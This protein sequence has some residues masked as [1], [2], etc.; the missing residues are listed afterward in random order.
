MPISS[1]L[2]QI[3]RAPGLLISLLLCFLLQAKA[4]AVSTDSLRLLLQQSAHDS[5]K[6]L[7]L[8]QLAKTSI[9]DSPENTLTYAQQALDLSENIGFRQGKVL[10]LNTL[11]LAYWS[12]GELRKGLSYFLDSKKEAKNLGD[13]NLFAQNLGSLGLIYRASGNYQMSLSYYRSA[14]PVF[15]ELNNMERIAT[16]YNNMGKCFLEMGV[17]DS[18][19]H[20]FNKSLPL[21]VEYRPRMLPITTFNLAD[22]WYRQQQYDKAIPIL[23]ECLSHAT[24]N[25][26]KR[27]TIRSKQLM[28]EIY[29]LEN[30]TAKAATLART[31]V[32]M[33]E[34]SKVKELIYLSYFTLSK[35]LAAQQCYEQAYHYSHLSTLYKDS[36]Q[37][38]DVQQKLDF[39][40]FEIQQSDLELLK[41]EQEVEHLLIARQ[42]ATIYGLG[43]LLL[44]SAVILVFVVRSRRE[45]H[46]NNQ[47]L[48]QTNEE[49]RQQKEALSVQSKKLEELNQLK[50]NLFSI[51]SHDLRSPLNTL[52]G[53][54]SLLENGLLSN[55]EFKSFLPELL[56]NVDH[57]TSLLD[58]LLHWAKSQQQGVYV[59]PKKIN[60]RA[61][62]HNKLELLQRQAMQK[63]LVLENNVDENLCAFADE[64]M[65][66]IVLQNLVSNAIKFCRPHDRITISTKADDTHIT[67]CVA[68]S[69]MG[70]SGENLEKL[71]QPK[72][73]TTRGTANEK[74]TGLGLLLC[75]DFV[76]KNGGHIWVESE[77][78]K[79]SCFYFTLPRVR[80]AQYAAQDVLT[81]SSIS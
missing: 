72:S 44:L 19:L 13:D 33:A 31:A 8:N 40:D 22:L 4:Q 25:D 58:N 5:S 14:V 20:Y 30:R 68:D 65:M 67:V 77:W 47:L 1:P 59:N 11:G 18:A 32:D 26:D 52:S 50:D 23:E 46:L 29:L 3:S 9:Y 27:A 53:S 56:K 34:A 60:L 12:K 51:I 10:S 54:L 78:L 73:F 41:K 81:Q 24:I 43:L 80:N 61:L 63:M 74:G 64:I 21:T 2:Q 57:T 39:F 75:K 49:V 55:A 71:F 28:A 7:L 36:V 16:T 45:K 42:R 38:K 37:A 17:Y 62:A 15:L 66:Q 79:G 48:L 6:V 70:I 35:V 76:E 69:G